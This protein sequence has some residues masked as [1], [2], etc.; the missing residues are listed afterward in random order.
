MTALNGRLPSTSLVTVQGTMRLEKKAAASWKRLTA[1][2]R[3]ATRITA[4]ITSPDGAYRTYDRQKSLSGK[5]NHQ[6]KPGYSIHGLGRCV[7]IYNWAEIGS[8]RLDAIAA[9]HG[10]KRTIAGEPWHYQY[11]PNRDTHLTK[12]TPAAPTKRRK[13]MSDFRYTKVN[14]NPPL[15]TYTDGFNVVHNA[16]QEETKLAREGRD[17]GL[18]ERAKGESAAAWKK[19]QAAMIALWEREAD[20]KIAALR[21]FTRDVT[22]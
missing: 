8:A 18:I 4:L 20:A 13:L 15:Y 1:A 5:G 14:G 2:I 3:S 6:Y 12:P 19:R 11:S 9:K 21:G 22:P 16:S 10:W 7:D 17:N